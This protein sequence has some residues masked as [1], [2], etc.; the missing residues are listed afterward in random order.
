MEV[1]IEIID[2]KKAAQYLEYNKLNRPLSS[3]VVAKYTKDMLE[4]QFK[5]TGD[6]IKFD[7]SGALSDGQ[8]RLQAIIR[9]NIPQQMVVTRGLEK[10][11]FAFMD[12]GKRRNCADTLS[13]SG[14]KNTSRMAAALR[15]YFLT[16]EKK[17]L[18]VTDV[19]SHG[20]VSNKKLLSL[21]ELNPD[22]AGYIDDTIIFRETGRIAGHGIFG[23]FFEAYRNDPEKVM[24]F[25]NKLNNGVE[26]YED[27]PILL[28]RNYLLKDASSTKKLPIG[29]K[30]YLIA[31][32]WIDCK[33]ENP[34]RKR[35]ELPQYSNDVI[36]PAIK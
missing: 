34:V 25:F 33:K 8:H 32:A 31:R 27:H 22:F 20:G 9:S 16:K 28:T 26:L 15:V 24:D 19:K 7:D 5:F 12:M 17:T 11:A 13:I 1:S 2:S 23:L 4:G 29:I 35:I 3:T 18:V 36:F 30:F 14:Y 6:S 10:D 21:I